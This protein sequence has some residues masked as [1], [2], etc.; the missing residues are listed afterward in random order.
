MTL[1]HE[2]RRHLGRLCFA[3]ILGALLFCCGDEEVSKPTPCTME[4][5]SGLFLSY[6]PCEG[7]STETRCEAKFL[8]GLNVSCRAPVGEGEGEGELAC[9]SDADCLWNEMCDPCAHPSCPE[10][11]DCVAACLP[12]R[13]P[14]E[15]ERGCSEA[16]PDC[17]DGSTSV[18]RGSCWLCVS[19]FS[20]APSGP[21][22]DGEH[23]ECSD[24]QPECA[25]QVVAVRGGCW[26]CVVGEGCL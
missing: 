16:R 23:L 19:V 26:E 14:S 25:G 9:E 13:C 2:E 6:A 21:C 11:L 1:L 5:S 3:V 4:C 18:M 10:C 17:G 12:Q 15:P 22:D 20:C 7:D 24:H 8:C